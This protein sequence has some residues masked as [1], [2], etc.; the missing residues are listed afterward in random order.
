MKYVLEKI[1]LTE[2]QPHDNMAGYFLAAL[3]DDYKMP[4]RY[5]PAKKVKP[6]P[7]PSPIPLEPE[8]SEETCRIRAEKTTGV[9]AKYAMSS[10]V[11]A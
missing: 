8:L 2:R 5:V 6:K 3:R 10:G 1:E 7:Q 4:V 9:A 11:L